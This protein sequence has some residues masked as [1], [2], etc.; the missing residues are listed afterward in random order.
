MA[1]E[2]LKRNWSYERKSFALV[3]VW[4]A[5]LRKINSYIE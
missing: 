1:Q 3:N 5:V 4:G 2:A